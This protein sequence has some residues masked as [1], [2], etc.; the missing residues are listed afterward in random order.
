MNLA[1]ASRLQ[2]SSLVLGSHSQVVASG[3]EDDLP[4]KLKLM[5]E[6]KKGTIKGRAPPLNAKTK[7]CAL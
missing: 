1:R 4:T 2:W 5:K 6:G 7:R 3:Q